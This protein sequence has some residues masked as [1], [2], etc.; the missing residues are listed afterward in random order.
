MDPRTEQAVGGK[1]VWRRPDGTPI[2]CHEKI[3]VMNQ[4]LDELRQMTQD[5]LEDAL[6][7]GA[8]EAQVREVLHRLVDELANPYG[9]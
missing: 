7:M 4:N 8:S 2:A 9:G 1:L 3:K 6:L 5:A